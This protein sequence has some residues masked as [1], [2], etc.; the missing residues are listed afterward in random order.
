LFET[1]KL[2]NRFAQFK[3]SAYQCHPEAKAEGSR[4]L[5]CNELRF[6]ADAPNDRQE[7][8]VPRKK[9]L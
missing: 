4:L 5:G 1:F 9:A 6:F 3:P 8:F 2:F 7:K